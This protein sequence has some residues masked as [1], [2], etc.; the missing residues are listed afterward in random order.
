[1]K[2]ESKVYALDGRV[3]LASHTLGPKMRSP[4]SRGQRGALY[5]TGAEQ[6]PSRPGLWVEEPD[7]LHFLGET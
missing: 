4:G 1:M 6:G 3:T 5:S 2:Q 7:S